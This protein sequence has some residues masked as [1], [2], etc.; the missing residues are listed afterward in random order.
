MS[1][2]LLLLGVA[3]AP[4]LVI[5]TP[6]IVTVQDVQAVHAAYIAAARTFVIP[7]QIRALVRAAGTTPL[8]WLAHL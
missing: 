2:L 6:D 8:L 7:W 5:S 4:L 1:L 3:S